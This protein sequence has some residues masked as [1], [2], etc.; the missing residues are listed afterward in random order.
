MNVSR[1]EV[2]LVDYPY[3]SSRGSKVRPVLIV[4]NDRDN[5]RL[6]NTIVAQIS[7]R[8]GR[9]SEPTQTM[10]EL[11]S[12][13]GKQSG[14]RQDSI[15][16]CVNVFTVGKDKLLRRLGRLPLDAMHEVGESLRVAIALK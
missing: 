11:T 12:T 1:G 10:I 7:S 16:N 14:L 3:G 5:Q 9:S 8:I 13:A 15:V 4:Q 2:Y 6:T